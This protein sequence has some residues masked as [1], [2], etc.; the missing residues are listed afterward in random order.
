MKRWSHIY[1]N[2][3]KINVTDPIAT[4]EILAVR[5]YGG[6]FGKP[7]HFE[8]YIYVLQGSYIFMHTLL[9]DFMLSVTL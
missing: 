5:K 7:P 6:I 9:L 8:P 1:Q 4:A 3:V 2:K